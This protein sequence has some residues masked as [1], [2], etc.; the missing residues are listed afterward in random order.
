MKI[1]RLILDDLTN[2]NQEKIQFSIDVE[3]G[4]SSHP[5]K[6]SSKYFYDDE[7]SQIFQKIT[8]L[9]EYYPTRT[10]FQILESCKDILA[11]IIN[12][13]EVDIVELG[14]GDG[15]K[16]KIII[17][18][19]LEKKIKVNFFPIDISE[20][21]L[22]QLENNLK[23]QS[24]L[25]MHGIV[26]D[27]LKG[28]SFARN[29]SANRQIV[30]F[31]GSNIGN[32]NRDESLEILKDIRKI[33]YKKDF[34][35]VGFDLKKNI[36]MMTKAYNDKEGVTAEFN[37]NLLRRINNEL[38]GNFNLEHFS[39]QAFYNPEL[40]AMES[41]LIAL[42]E[43]D[44]TINSL[45]R[46]FHFEEYEPIHLEYSFKFLEKEI[47]EISLKGGFMPVKNF[48]DSQHLFVD[49]LWQV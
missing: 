15:H 32:F 33:M 17:N 42:K 38:G 8:Q 20:E 35:L 41:Y 25:C 21:A 10:E 49:A 13:N 18:S 39:H 3:N 34:L 28:L 7:G 40:G 11:E 46:T 9:E 43:Q 31:L 2:E 23:P 24:N 14:V 27:Y 12:V 36:E 30:L 26:A 45:N 22:H 19:F 16:T 4:L 48:K 5:K 47:N 6:I 29:R 1:T 37:L 44:V